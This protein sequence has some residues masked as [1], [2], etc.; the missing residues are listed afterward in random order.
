[1]PTEESLPAA[2]IAVRS[3]DALDTIGKGVHEYRIQSIEV[4]PLR[5]LIHQGVEYISPIQGRT[6]GYVFPELRIRRIVPWFR[7]LR[8]F[9]PRL[10]YRARGPW[11]CTHPESLTSW[12]C[13]DIHICHPCRMR[14]ARW[15]CARSGLTTSSGSYAS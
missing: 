3:V 5:L 8:H 6:E 4:P 9:S 12:G 14:S 15:D 13:G 11:F 7:L 2:D 1:M 10:F